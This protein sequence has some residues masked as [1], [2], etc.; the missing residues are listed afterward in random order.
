LKQAY[1][2]AVLVKERFFNDE[3]FLHTFEY[4]DPEHKTSLSGRS[5]IITLELS[6]LDKVVTKPI[7]KMTA[8][9]HWGVFFRYLPDKNKRRIINEILEQEE[10]IAMASEVLMSISK[11]EAERARLMSE[12]KYQMDTQSK[13]GHARREGKL[14]GRE[15]IIELLKSG[16]S[17]EEILRDYSE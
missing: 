11:D 17:P 3:V 14:E 12:F 10:G 13:I 6:K 5:R 2:I 8:A 4:Y 15:E 1:Q 16:K 9:E 7:G